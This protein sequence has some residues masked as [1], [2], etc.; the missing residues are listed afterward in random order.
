MNPSMCGGLL[1]MYEKTF[2]SIH[3]NF[4]QPIL[5]ANN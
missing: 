3:N 4:N 5:I 2:F 1:E